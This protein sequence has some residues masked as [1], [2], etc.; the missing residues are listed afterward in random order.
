MAAIRLWW[1]RYRYDATVQPQT[2]MYSFVTV[3]HSKS[4]N[5]N[6]W[7]WTEDSMALTWEKFESLECGSSSL[8]T[9]A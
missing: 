1:A 2:V 3:H 9:L 6:L 8:Q 7:L 4:W 5:L